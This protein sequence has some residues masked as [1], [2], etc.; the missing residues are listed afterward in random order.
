MFSFVDLLVLELC[1]V[2]LTWNAI[3]W[4]P[5][6]FSEGGGEERKRSGDSSS[7]ALPYALGM[8]IR[9]ETVILEVMKE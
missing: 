3:V 1:L 8:S 7:A 5:D 6:L 2:L 4:G 9:E